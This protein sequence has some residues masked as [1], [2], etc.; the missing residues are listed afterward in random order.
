MRE[1]NFKNIALNKAAVSITTNLYDRRALDSTMDQPL[2][3]SLNH[4]TFL[5]SSSAKVRETLTNDGGLERLVSILH[6]CHKDEYM[7]A[8]TSRSVENEKMNALIAWKWTLAF[9]C[10][11]LVATRGNERIRKRVIEAGVLPIISTVLDNYL[12]FVRNFDNQLDAHLNEKFL[13]IVANKL[14]KMKYQASTKISKLETDDSKDYDYFNICNYLSSECKIF[15]C[16]NDYLSCH[17][18]DSVLGG[19][20]DINELHIKQNMHSINETITCP[21]SFLNGKLIP[22]DDDVVWSLQL[23]A[24][25]SKYSSLKRFFQYTHLVDSLSLRVILDSE[26]DENSINENIESYDILKDLPKLTQS[27]QETSSQQS[28]LQP[29]TQQFI[30]GSQNS[31]ISPLMQTLS[32]HY[33]QQK[34]EEDPKLINDE[35]KSSSTSTNSSI[36]NNSILDDDSINVSTLPSTICESND[37]NFNKLNNSIG[38]NP[39]RISI[40]QNTSTNENINAGLIDSIVKLDNCLTS[41]NSAVVNDEETLSSLIEVC[42]KLNNYYEKSLTSHKIRSINESKLETRNYLDKYNY[43]TYFSSKNIN[44]NED[45]NSSDSSYKF[46]YNINLFPLVEKFTMKTINTTDMCY[47]A[48]VVMRNSCRKD[49]ERGGVRQCAYHG[50]GKWE[51]CPRQFAKCRRCKR[52]KYCSKNCQLKAWNYHKHWCIDSTSTSSGSTTNTTSAATVPNTSIS[53]T[54]T[55]ENTNDTLGNNITSDVLNEM[56]NQ[57]GEFINT[58]DAGGVSEE[59]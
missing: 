40:V 56:G 17:K 49:E 19:P 1:S 34:K 11:V 20:L 2:V 33:S 48:G 10:L 53:V 50:C 51:Q 58:I 46:K 18:K 4:L 52:T 57:N 39:Q 30:Q 14:H 12:L 45:Q 13:T 55:P 41:T 26:D 25:T 22:K 23:L 43:E 9:Q 44:N 27:S 35:N 7:M 15:R 36:Y 59:N 3:N 6:E 5:T 38:L 29:S 28:Y 32:Q 47:W 37:L 16:L 8:D 54:P 31:A 24:F 21:R 42:E